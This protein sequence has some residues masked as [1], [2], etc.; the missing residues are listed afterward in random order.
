[1][2]RQR[3]E[4][5]KRQRHQQQ[6]DSSKAAFSSCRSGVHLQRARERH[7]RAAS[8]KMQA[9]VHGI[10]TQKMEEARKWDLF[11]LHLQRVILQVYQHNLC[12][13]LLSF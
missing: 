12:A 11:T 3:Q 7:E 1:M 13:K 6:M 10:A 4:D 8:L 5:W 2:K 9:I